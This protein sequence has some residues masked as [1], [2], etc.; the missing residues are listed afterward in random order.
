MPLSQTKKTCIILIEGQL[1]VGEERE[2]Q[3]KE[4][5]SIMFKVLS[6]TH[7]QQENLIQIMQDH[8]N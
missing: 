8:S 3:E 2:L 5:E 1:G 6:E 7:K 4:N